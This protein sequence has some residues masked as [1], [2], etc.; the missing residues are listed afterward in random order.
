MDVQFN[1]VN[2]ACRIHS[3]HFEPRKLVNNWFYKICCPKDTFTRTTFDIN[4]DLKK[5]RLRKKINEGR[6]AEVFSTNFNGYVLRILRGIKFKPKT[7][8]PFDDPNGLTV[9]ADKL[10][11]T[12]LMKFI[13]GEPLFGKDWYH[14]R[15][16]S[17]KAYMKEF[18]KIRNL[19]D[20]TFAEYM[21]DIV[22]IRKN[23]YDIDDINPNNFLLDG[24]RIRIVD[25]EKKDRTPKIYLTDFD[26]L[27]NRHQLVGMFKKMSLKELDSFSDVIKHFYDRLVRIALREGHDIGIPKTEDDGFALKSYLINYLYYKN[28]DRVKELVSRE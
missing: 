14:S 27:V 20:E 11:T 1:T 2:F 12:Q 16:M 10:N 5:V 13:E 22:R 9:A 18:E 7:L 26:P 19:P 3:A 25:L 17:K 21:R 15:T 24:K 4:N 6:S 23:G 28:L 8:T